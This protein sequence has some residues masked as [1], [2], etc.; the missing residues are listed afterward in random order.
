MKSRISKP[1]RDEAKDEIRKVQGMAKGERVK[2]GGGGLKEWVNLASRS[3]REEKQKIGDV[4]KRE[5]TNRPFKP[6]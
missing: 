3:T 2:G 4:G 1:K 6:V 5:R